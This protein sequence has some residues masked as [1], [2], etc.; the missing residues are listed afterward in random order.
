VFL[1]AF[2][3][4]HLERIPKMGHPAFWEGWAEKLLRMTAENG[5]GAGGDLSCAYS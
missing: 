3:L 5:I 2:K 1:K 4:W